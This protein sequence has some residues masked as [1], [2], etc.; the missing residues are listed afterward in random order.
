MQFI[1]VDD[2]KQAKPV[3]RGMGGLF[4]LGGVFVAHDG[5]PKLERDLEALARAAGFPTHTDEFKWSPR[6]GT[7]MYTNLIA[8]D[9]EEFFVSVVGA[10]ASA[11][12]SV[13]FCM[14]DETRGS[15][16]PGVGPEEDV[17][18][19]CIERANNRLKRIGEH[20]VIVA[21]RPGGGRK[22]EDDF[23]ADCADLLEN[24]TAYVKPDRIAI[25]VLT[26]DSKMVRALQAADVVAG[27]TLAYVS[28]EK[29]WSPPVF[30][31]LLPLFYKDSGRC[32]GVSAKLH[33][34][35]VYANLYHWLFA[36]STYWKRGMGTPMPVWGM[37]YE[38]SADIP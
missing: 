32:G 11:R 37:P 7:W 6:R 23:I 13:S 5:L 35:F 3:R 27:C 22:A 12:A 15:A 24:G 18:R 36:D 14:V 21:D 29:T 38:T 26:T 17:T 31:R 8:N 10:L 20:G 34:D 2:S 19:L 9:R 28:G 33:P 4:A 25:N 1:F 30:A 16:N